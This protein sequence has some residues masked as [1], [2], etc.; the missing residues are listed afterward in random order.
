MFIH[1][2]NNLFVSSLSALDRPLPIVQIL[3]HLSSD[4]DFHGMQCHVS[5][6]SKPNENWGEAARDTASDNLTVDFRCLPKVVLSVH[7]SSFC[8][9]EEVAVVDCFAQYTCNQSGNNDLVHSLLKAF[10]IHPNKLLGSPTR[11]YATKRLSALSPV[12]L[13]SCEV[14]KSLHARSDVWKEKPA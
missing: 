12:L 14:W 5:L 9:H 8:R 10:S 4:Q 2:G 6:G 3:T 11:Q 13:S 1:G 7:Y